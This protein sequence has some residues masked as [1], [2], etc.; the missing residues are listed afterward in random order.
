MSQPYNVFHSAEFTDR[1]SEFERVLTILKEKSRGAVIFEGARGS[2]KSAF[3]LELYRRLHE[4]SEIRPFLIG[5]FPYS[6]DEFKE[7]ENIRLN[8][9]R[10]FER[11]D[12]PD[13]LNRLARYLEIDFIESD[14]LSFQKDYFARGLAYRTTKTV[15]VLLVDS[16]YE[17]PEEVRVEIE[18]Y[19]F[20][21][22][23]ASERVFLILSGRGKRP[24][25][26]SPELQ[27]A[28]ILTLDP[29]D[30]DNVKDQLVR[31]E[32]AGK[33]KR[34][35]SEYDEIAELSCGY[36][37]IARVMAESEKKSLTDAL[38]EAIDIMIKDTLPEPEREE[39]KYS[40]TR[41]QIEKLSLVDIPFRIPDVEAYLFP[42][43]PERRAKTNELVALLL[44]SGLLRYEGKGYQLNPSVT[45][46]IRKWLA[47]KEQYS[48][49]FVQL[50]KVSE[51]LQ[52]AYPSAKAWYQRMLPKEGSP[53]DHT[54]YSSNLGKTQYAA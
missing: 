21:P 39:K 15:P 51:D 53:S 38:D 48:N 17:C 50:T 14:D 44:A 19:I 18:K 28:E 13:V 35:E 32:K 3:L 40:Q 23:L 43:D 27:T 29:L 7:K 24:I 5:L 4:Q 11:Q 49:Y 20:A 31:L 46:P 25:W 30:K 8:S 54:L 2:G 42:D 47:R 41:S 37:L 1:D 22:L 9:E 26:S 33:S 10:A 16:V 6:A 36:P 34:D 52:E 12:I 45:H